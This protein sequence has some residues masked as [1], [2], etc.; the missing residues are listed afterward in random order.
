[1][2]RDALNNITSTVVGGLVLWSFLFMGYVM[3]MAR[4]S[5]DA[6]IRTAAMACFSSG[7]CPLTLS[8]RPD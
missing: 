4:E 3:E 8:L 6:P 7:H 2:R 1:M 5:H